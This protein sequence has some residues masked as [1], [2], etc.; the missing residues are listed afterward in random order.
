[1]LFKP[2]KLRPFL[3]F[4][5]SELL[6]WTYTCLPTT[7]TYPGP[8]YFHTAVWKWQPQLHPKYPGPRNG[9]EKLQQLRS[10][11]DV[12]YNKDDWCIFAC[13]YS[14]VSWHFEPAPIKTFSGVSESNEEGACG[15]DVQ[16]VV[17][18]TDSKQQVGYTS[19]PVETLELRTLLSRPWLTARPS[20]MQQT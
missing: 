18:C 7:N 16:F 14:S 15:V 13:A 6:S 20:G 19:H 1:M 8:F 9:N 5:W 11:P 12:I 17:G 10:N 3:A 4:H 2:V